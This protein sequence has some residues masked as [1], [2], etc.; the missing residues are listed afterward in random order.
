MESHALIAALSHPGAYPDRPS[1]VSVRQT[2]ISWLFF[3]ERFVY[4]VKKPVDFGFLDFTTL[5]ARKFFCG[6]EVRL[7]RRLA[8]EVYPG[9]GEAERCLSR[10]QSAFIDTSF[11]RARHRRQAMQ[12]AR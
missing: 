7:N 5:E 12:L 9:V 11:Q 8:P 4:K 3:T 2:H 10:D 6:E 1:Q